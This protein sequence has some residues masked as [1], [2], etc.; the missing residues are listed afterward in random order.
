MMLILLLAS[1]LSYSYAV[2]APLTLL[3]DSKA[4]CMDGTL[5]GYYFQSKYTYSCLEMF[6]YYFNFFFNVSVTEATRAEDS[7]KWVIHLQGGGECA[8]KDAC[9]GELNS[10]LGSS[11]YFDPSMQMWFFNYDNTNINPDWGAA[12]H[13][14]IPY[15]S[16]DLHS[17]TVTAPSD[18]TWGLYFSGHLIF[19]AVVEELIA[20]YELGSATDIVLSGDSAGGIGVWM[21]VDYLAVKI[22]EINANTRVVGAPIAGFYF[23]A[24]EPYTGPDHTYSTLANFSESGMAT[25]YNLWQSYVDLTCLSAKTKDPHACT[26]AAYSY[27]YI[28]SETFIIEAQTDQVVLEAHDWVPSAPTLCNNPEL[29]YVASWRDEMISFLTDHGIL[30]T[31]KNHS[32]AFV[33]ACYT[34]TGFSHDAPKINAIDYNTAFGNWYFKRTAADNYKL[35]DVCASITDPNAINAKS[36][37]FCNPSCTSPC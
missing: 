6:N 32:G 26:L 15:C 16:G 4:R 2:N 19:E 17:G 28:S 10:N 9:Y 35:Y 23:Y 25:A 14:H 29:Q 13:V 30:D 1:Y 5:S 7:T 18:S 37:I 24:D 20:K 3:T 36:N 8:T 31:T 22:H 21:N 33:P 27:P 11:K 34:H 12:N